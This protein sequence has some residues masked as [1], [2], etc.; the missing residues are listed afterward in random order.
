MYKCLDLSIIE[1][2]I[3]AKFSEKE[4]VDQF[5]LWFLLRCLIWSNSNFPGVRLRVDLKVTTKYCDSWIINI[6]R[7]VGKLL[8]SQ[9]YG[10]CGSYERYYTQ[11]LL[12][13]RIFHRSQWFQGKMTL[14]KGPK[15][16][17]NP[18]Y[19]TISQNLKKLQKVDPQ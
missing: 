2:T 8:F 12:C 16:Q 17:K 13:K 11:K 7:T 10:S 5:V 18:F 9:K 14:K 1:I 19:S 4:S 6:G 3:K 15:N